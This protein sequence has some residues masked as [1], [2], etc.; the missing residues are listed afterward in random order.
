MTTKVF[1]ARDLKGF[2]ELLADNVVLEAPGGLR[3]RGKDACAQFF[4]GWIAA[5]PDAHVD[6]QNV[7]I[8]DVGFEEGIFTG[9]HKGIM[10]SPTGDIPPTGRPVWTNYTQAPASRTE[11]THPELR[12]GADLRWHFLRHALCD[13][14]NPGQGEHPETVGMFRLFAE[15]IASHFDASEQLAA[16]EADLLGERTASE[17]R[18]QF[19]VVLG[20]DLRN[21][22]ASID[23]GAKIFRKES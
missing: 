16:R 23:A 7:E 1:N 8:F 22:L 15:L 10:H 17:V 9:T 12:L 11:N 20:H 19:I 13:R 21:P 6:I 3:G 18:E 4:G 14:P 5:F 2:A